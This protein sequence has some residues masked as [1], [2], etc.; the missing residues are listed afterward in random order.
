VNTFCL[1]FK[2]F[3]DYFLYGI[4]LWLA[5]CAIA[6]TL[7]VWFRKE[8]RTVRKTLWKRLIVGIPLAVFC[9]ILIAVS[10]RLQIVQSRQQSSV[11]QQQIALKH[12]TEV[13]AKY[14]SKIA[15][16][17]DKDQE[18]QSDFRAHDFAWLKSVTDDLQKQGLNTGKVVDIY[19]K[20]QPFGGTKGETIKKMA[21]ELN[22]LANQLP[23][24]Q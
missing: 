20:S 18:L 9:L 21:D 12:E 7:G 5:A 11:Y 3:G 1:I 19:N 4:G 8:V 17:F 14:L 2:S 23:T 6:P 22:V 16:D 13:L 10:I 24:P 15:V